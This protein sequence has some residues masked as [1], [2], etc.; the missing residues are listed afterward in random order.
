MTT[1]TLPEQARIVAGMITLGE[2]IAYGRDADLLIQ[3]ATIVEAQRGHN[4]SFD[5]LERLKKALINL[6][7]ST[8]EG[9]MEHFGAQIETQLY[10]LCRGVDNLLAQQVAPP[11]DQQA[12]ELCDKCGWKAIMPGEPCFVCNMQVAAPQVPMTTEEALD[13][14]P[15][16]N[17]GR[18]DALA[19]M[20]RAVERHHGIGAKP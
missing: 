9:G 7:Y 18:I 1:K 19:W 20:A 15:T 11:Y 5:L 4:L 8:P 3:L 6:G 16:N 10:N 2:R 17:M 13:L 12:L 14:M